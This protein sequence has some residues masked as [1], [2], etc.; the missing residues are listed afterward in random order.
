MDGLHVVRNSDA[1]AWAEYWSPEQG[2]VR[3]DPTAAVAPNRIDRPRPP[4]RYPEQLP[5][6][7]RGLDPA[8]WS[9]LRSYTDAA[10]HRWNVWVLQYSRQ[11]QMSLLK[12]WGFES[13]D[14][15]TLVRVCASV[16]A[17][18][19][20]GGVLWLW[21]QRP[22]V[23]RSDWHAPLSKL[24]RGLLAAGLPAPEGC[25][26]PAPALSWARIVEQHPHN[27]DQVA[28]A[29]EIQ[30]HLRHLDALRYASEKPPSPRHRQDLIK[31]TLALASRWAELGQRAPVASTRQHGD[32]STG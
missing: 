19:A 5:Q 22:R 3:V 14:W 16:V 12:D 6:A 15:V 28:L 1:H 20:L 17:T 29:S 7:L 18:L 11:K 30:A 13:P 4:I 8:F 26:A 25:P 2:W 21:W 24:H 9:G 23:R 31:E 32:P 10:N 27:T